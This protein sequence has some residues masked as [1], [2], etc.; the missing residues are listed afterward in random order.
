MTVCSINDVE[1]G[2]TVTG[3]DYNTIYVENRNE[4]FFDVFE[5]A[6][7]ES[8][9]LLERV[10]T[11]ENGP[12]VLFEVTINGK[13]YSFA[14]GDLTQYKLDQNDFTVVNELFKDTYAEEV[15]NDLN[16]KY[17]ICRGRYM[18][19]DENFRGYSYHYDTTDRIHI[20]LT[21]NEDAIFISLINIK[22]YFLIK[23]LH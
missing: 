6:V 19:L 17:D 13:R 9:I 4:V 1:L 12:I 21:T 20:P 5:C 14:S 3:N 8:N 2:F 18:T 16:E 11:H 23:Q 10:D 22:L 15:Y 7:G